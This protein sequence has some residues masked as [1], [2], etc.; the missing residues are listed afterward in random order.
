MGEIT[1]PIKFW[2]GVVFEF[3]ERFQVCALHVTLA[4]TQKNKNFVFIRLNL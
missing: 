3:P 1:V 2:G 4:I